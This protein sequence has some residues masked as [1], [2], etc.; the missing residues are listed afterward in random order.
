MAKLLKLRRGTTS[1]HSSFTGAEGE[2]TVDT[3]KE[4]LV[5]HNGST[6]G[7]FPIARENL[8]NVSS[9]SITGRL[10]SGSIASDKLAADSIVA[11]KIADD[12]IN[13][14]HYVDGSIDN[15]HLADNSVSGTKIQSGAIAG[16]KLVN[17]TVTATQIANN[18]ITAVQIAAD[19]VGSS[20][21]AAD[22][23]NG[24]HIANNS[25]NSEH[26]IA[27]SIDHAHL[28]NDII[29]SDNIQDNAINSE[30][31]VDASID[32]AHLADNAVGTNE[33]A[34]DAVSFDK[35]Q[36][37]DTARILGRDT[38]GSGNVEQLTAAETRVLLNIENGATADQSNAEIRAAVEAASDSNVF[39]DADHSKLNGI[40]ASATADQTAAEIL[41]AI[42]TVDGS[43]SGLDADTLDGVS[44]GGFLQSHNADEA[45]ADITFSGGAG[46]VSIAANS[47]IRLAD[48]NWT[49]D[50]SSPKLQAHGNLLYISGGS[51]GIIFRE[52]ATDRWQ[53]DGS[54]HLDPSSDS[55]YDI[56]QSNLRVRNGYFDTL[57]GDGSNLTGIVSFVS[58][59]ILIWSGAE[60]AIP[61][62][63][64]L[65]NGSNSTP[66]LRDRFV[67]GAGSTYSVGATG[68]ANNVTLTANQIASHSHSFS[69]NA[70]TGNQSA[71]HSHGDGN[72]ATNNTG[73]HSH[74][75]SGNTNN[76]GNHTHNITVGSGG[77]NDP[78]TQTRFNE[79]WN[80]NNTSTSSAGA[81]SHNV[82]GNT[83][84][85]GNHSHSVS[86][87]SG[88]QSANHTHSV[89]ISGNTGNS[90]NTAAHENRPPYYALC[91]IMKS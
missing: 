33:I 66:D 65:C 85:T 40:E 64:V 47:D 37:I 70:N 6:A 41:T 25:I 4:S 88:N 78:S 13:S 42:K 38:S 19:A 34:A 12:Q 63:W 52:N 27:G 32:N 62:G 56:G 67:V 51:S 48:G 22:A 35:M 86:G 87:N 71:N 80:P 76:T 26:Y 60:N 59:M 36:N 49:G 44:S 24:G 73:G 9:A 53:I 11:A 20:E 91:Y 69:G 50:S 31:Y 77:D 81:H 82:S 39:T 79:Y 54:G 15:A 74:N 30:H 84:N 21:L 7:G 16:S 8:S 10:G 45:T 55:S 14:E 1:Q 5:V 29:D 90:G 72:Y 2:V 17:N 89:S 58:G 18:T 46:A 61:S 57:Y 23:V 43:G 3:D 68:G 28:A 83:N 75:I